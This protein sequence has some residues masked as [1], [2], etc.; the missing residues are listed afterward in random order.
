MTKRQAP[1]K[2]QGPRRRGPAAYVE[3]RKKQF[4]EPGQDVGDV[5]AQIEQR[6]SEDIT[7]NI[8][9]SSRYP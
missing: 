3:S 8:A 5:L 2:P 7:S 1:A 6:W 4:T 9:H